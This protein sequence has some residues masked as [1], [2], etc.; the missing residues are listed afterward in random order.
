MPDRQSDA[1]TDEELAID[2]LSNYV[3]A[4]RHLLHSLEDV[5]AMGNDGNMTVT[6]ALGEFG[7]KSGHRYQLQVRVTGKPASFVERQEVRV[8]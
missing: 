7:D 2:S 8:A 4:L 5:K 6:M 1:T 3:Y